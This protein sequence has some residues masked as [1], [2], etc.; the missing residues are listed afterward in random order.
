MTAPADILVRRAGKLGAGSP[1]YL[2]E[3]LVQNGLGTELLREVGV[4]RVGHH[5][6]G[7]RFRI[8]GDQ[9]ESFVWF[10]F[11]VWCCVRNGWRC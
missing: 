2:K 4:P 10:G 11:G 5:V 1:V 9:D 8:E 6:F 7:I 3:F